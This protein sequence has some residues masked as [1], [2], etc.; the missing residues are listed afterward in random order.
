MQKLVTGARGVL[1]LLHLTR[2]VQ[3]GQKDG[4]NISIARSRGRYKNLNQIF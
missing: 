4:V 1:L 3:E 2:R